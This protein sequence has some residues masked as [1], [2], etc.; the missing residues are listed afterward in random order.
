MT[1]PIEGRC[2]PGFEAV[3]EAFVSNFSEHGEVGAG[4]HVIVDGEVVVDLVGG[5]IDE[6]RTRPWTPE[7]LVDIYSVGKAFLGILVL[8]LVDDGRLALDQ[9]I[10]DVWPEFA[11]GGKG[12]ATVAQALSHRAGVPA[13]REVMTNAELFDWDRMVTAIAA[14][15]AWFEPGE[16]LVYHTNT[17]GHLVGEL[18]RRVTGDMPSEQMRLL[19]EPLDADVWFGV[20]AEEQHRCAEV[21]WAPQNPIPVF[22]NFEGLD[23]DVLMNVL[24]HFNPP[25]YSSVGVVNTSEWRS[26][27]IGSTSGHATAAGIARIYDAL[28]TDG[29]I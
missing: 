2:A 1:V 6:E 22:K 20:P 25:A 5:W 4:V 23:G 24:A 14:T 19:A 28:I 13:I 15:E 12:A 8:R 18:V 16:R 3:R 17:Y 9:P 10:A 21:I 7:T 27:Q 26:A 29:L 11:A